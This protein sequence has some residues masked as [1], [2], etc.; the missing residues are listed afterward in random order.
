MSSADIEQLAAA[1]ARNAI[2]LG[3]M[4]RV[5]DIENSVLFLASDLSSYITGQTLHVDGGAMAS[6]GWYNFPKLGFRNRVPLQ[7]IASDAYG[8]HDAT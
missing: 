8:L 6:A 1:Q 7:V 5:E 3:R 4:G 2:P